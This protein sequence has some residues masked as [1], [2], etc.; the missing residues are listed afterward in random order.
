[1]RK[2]HP[3]RHALVRPRNGQITGD[4]IDIQLDG[5]DFKGGVVRGKAEVHIGGFPDEGCAE[6]TE[7][8]D[9]S[10]PG[11]D[12]R[13]F[14]EGQAGERLHVLDEES[15]EKGVNTVTGDRMR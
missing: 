8:H 13:V 1:M 15:G 10:K 12:R 4:R 2:A 7:N 5:I 11:Y 6:G 9:R 3:R 14:V